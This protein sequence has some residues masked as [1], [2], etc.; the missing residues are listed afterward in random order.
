MKKFFMFLVILSTA[1][2]PSIA[3]PITLQFWG[4]I[5]PA[6]GPQDIVDAWN[7][8]NPDIQVEYTRFSNDD[9]GNLKLETAVLAG[10]VDVLITYPVTALE[11]RS[12]AGMFAPLDNY[13]NSE[14]IN[15]KETFG[16]T[17]Y[18]KNGVTY[19]I[20]TLGG[21]N[22]FF[23]YNK[24]MIDAAKVQ[25]PANWTWEQYEEIAKKLTTGSGVNKVYGASFGGTTAADDW[26][27][28]PRFTLGGD[29]YYKNGGTES[30]FDHPLFLKSM[31]MLY[32]MMV[33]DK[34][35]INMM[36]V[37]TT[38]MD[39]GGDFTKGKIATMCLA[40][41]HLK[42]VKEDPHSFKTALAPAPTEPGQ[43][44]VYGPGLREWISIA[45][46]S[47]HKDQAWKFI[48]YFATEGY[49]PMAKA[50]RFPAWKGADTEKVME[51][52]LGPSRDK[53]FD[54]AS[55][56]KYGILDP[57]IT[58]SVVTITTAQSKI[59]ELMGTAFQKVLLNQATPEQALADLKKA[60]DK[61]IAEERAKAK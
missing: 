1:A 36:V 12:L 23:M 57:T 26:A 4:A 3:N 51:M 14:K 13:I 38:K 59:C 60:A 8:A 39:I 25:I 50:N 41:Y 28:I 9:A 24:D 46:K 27:I 19:F 49:Y 58:N 31:K 33:V 32:R 53:I 37:K 61:L 34:T 29:Y 10:Q 56:K 43:G 40:N 21:N 52:Y 20:P 7:K 42:N 47:K 55:F 18:G 35:F 44:K 48:K 6:Q 45:N 17:I 22:T 2:L 5:Q 30:N 16:D 15:L 11:N 54:V